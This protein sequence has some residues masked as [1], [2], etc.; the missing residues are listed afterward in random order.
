MR[1]IFLA[2]LLSLFIIPVLVTAQGL[3]PCGHGNPTDPGFKK[4]TIADFGVLVLNVFNFIVF[5]IS[6]P[7]AALLITIG[8][9]M[10][11]IS[12]G[13]PG[14]VGLANRMIWGA[15]WGLLLI[16]GSWLIVNTVISVLKGQ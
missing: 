9:I 8:G 14:L 12:G 1:K 7:L 10:L 13:N 5:W 2:I 15:I 11:L 3:V 16:W 6:T 4:C